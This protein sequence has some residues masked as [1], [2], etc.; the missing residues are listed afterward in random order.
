MLWNLGLDDDSNVGDGDDG[1]DADTAGN[2]D[3]ILM[4]LLLMIIL[5]L[6]SCEVVLGDWKGRI[7]VSVC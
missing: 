4:L 5:I 2:A 6:S 7:D 3:D 1:D